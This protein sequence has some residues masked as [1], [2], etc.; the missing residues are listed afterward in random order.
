VTSPAIAA[1]ARSGI[2]AVNPRK[3]VLPGC[4]DIRQYPPMKPRGLRVKTAVTL[5]VLGGTLLAAL[6]LQWVWWRTASQSSLQLVDVLSE[7]ITSTVRREWW[8]RIVAA[9]SA[10]SVAFSLLDRGDD[11]NIIR[12]ALG[13]ALEATRIPSALT[14]DAPGGVRTVARRAADGGVE[15]WREAPARSAAPATAPQWRDD[16]PSAVDGGQAVAYAGSTPFAG[17]LSVYIGAERFSDL[18]EAIPV[19]ST[20]AALVIDADGAVK[21]APRTFAYRNLKGVVDAAGAVVA[22]RPAGAKNIVES[23]RLVLDRAGYRASFSPLE[24]RGW[25]FVVIVPEAEFLSDIDMTTF[26]TLIGVPILALML[27]LAAALLAQRILS[28]PVAELT[29]DLRKVER[30]ELEDV[31]YRPGRLQEFDQLS[32]AMARMAT[33]LADFAKFIPTDLVRMLLAEGVRAAPGGETRELTMMF[34]DVAGFTKL[35]ERMGTRVIDIVS[36]YLDVVSRAV[37]ANGGTVDKFIGD[38]VMAFW[39]APRPDVGQARNACL[40]A[41]AALLAVRDVG[42]TD[43]QGEPLRIRIGLHAGPAVVGNIGS[44]RRLNYTAIGDA[45]NLASRLEGANKTFGTSIIVSEAVRTAAGDDVVTRELAEVAVVGK[46]EPVRIH[47]LL[48]FGG[49]RAKPDWAHTYEEAL[50]AYRKGAFDRAMGILDALPASRV[51]DKPAA[52]L[53]ASCEALRAAPPPAGW[54][55]VVVLDTK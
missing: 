24:F 22:A 13:A 46:S 7:Q 52:W 4:P 28:D 11:E 44:E 35:S 20:G 47:E 12:R 32:A 43:D 42:I 40:A 15:M 5:L 54:R 27:G 8:D 14:F 39:G 41:L 53:K 34:V 29:G 10:Y 51:D 26:R 31:A 36:R 50:A 48:G 25:Q 30:F 33:G 1:A 17:L 49:A 23:R 45:V 19:G 3:D 9:E 38:A 2:A 16:L 37:E 21:V 18:L 6:P 55:G